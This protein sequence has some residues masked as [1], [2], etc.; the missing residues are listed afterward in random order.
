MTQ[1]DY[2]P[3]SG[4]E[5]EVR[6]PQGV[7]DETR[8]TMPPTAAGG[9]GM[10][11]NDGVA[12]MPAMDAG[13]TGMNDMG[14]MGGMDGMTGMGSMTGMGT[15]PG[16]M[17]PEGMGGMAAPRTRSSVAQS[18]RMKNPLDMAATHSP[19]DTREAY[20]ASLRS[21]LHRNVG[22]FV[23]ATFLM[24]TQQAVTWQGILHSV[25][26]DYLVIYQPNYNRYVSCDLYAVKF[27]QFHDTKDI[28][29]C[30]TNW[31]LGAQSNW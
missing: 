16:Q 31:T 1:Q 13:M 20:L 10:W 5:G 28:P 6:L 30:S 3:Q 4:M 21:L 19:A 2:Q 29:Y 9:Q 18:Q 7:P 14:G 27:V 15:E 8:Y 17:P 22:Y 11:R 12:G 25:G 23:V 24:G 26:S